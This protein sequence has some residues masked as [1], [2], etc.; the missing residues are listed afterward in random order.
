MSSNISLWKREYNILLNSAKN[1]IFNFFFHLA[2]FQKSQ[3]KRTNKIKRKETKS[4]SFF[5]LRSPSSLLSLICNQRFSPSSH[6]LFLPPP[7]ASATLL[8]H[9]SVPCVIGKCLLALVNQDHCR[10][11]DPIQEDGQGGPRWGII[12]LGDEQGCL[13]LEWSHLLPQ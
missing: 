9:R 4:S 11:I 10:G 12:E 1:L 5:S 2:C 7:M 3:S 6:A 8:L 13:F